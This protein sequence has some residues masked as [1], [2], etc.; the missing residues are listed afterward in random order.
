MFGVGTADPGHGFELF[1]LVLLP[2]AA[3][4]HAMTASGPLAL[5]RMVILDSGGDGHLTQS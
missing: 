3:A 4:T 1:G 5:E 2:Q